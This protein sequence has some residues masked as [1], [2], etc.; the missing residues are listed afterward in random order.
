MQDLPWKQVSAVANDPEKQ[1]EL[2]TAFKL[3]AAATRHPHWT[4]HLVSALA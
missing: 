3:S 1:A 4:Q 2:R